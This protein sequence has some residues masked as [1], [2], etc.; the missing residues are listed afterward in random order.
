MV[1]KESNS[2]KVTGWGFAPQMRLL[3]LAF[4]LEL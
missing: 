3:D 1:A 4:P 2:S